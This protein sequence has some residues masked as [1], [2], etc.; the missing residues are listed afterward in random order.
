MEAAISSSL[1]HPN[2]VQTHTYSLQP[3]SSSHSSGNRVA[4]DTAV[5]G[6][7]AVWI[8]SSSNGAGGSASIRAP[9]PPKTNSTP[10][11]FEVQLVLEFCD[12]GTLREALDAWAFTTANGE[13]NYR[14]VLDT[15]CDVARGML[16]LHEL[17]IIH[18]DLKAGNVLLKRSA[19]EMR[20]VVAKVSDFGLSVKMDLAETHVSKMYQGTMTHMAPEVIQEGC[21]SKAGDV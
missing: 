15:A 2:I 5:S 17:N 20:G 14:A 6:S 9:P 10:S 19:S 11:G 7:H 1:S 21:Q 8:G 3:I 12:R 18:S 16:H 13:I 4:N